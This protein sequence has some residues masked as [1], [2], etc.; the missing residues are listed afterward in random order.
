MKFEHLKRT[1]IRTASDQLE[2]HEVAY[3]RSL[4]QQRLDASA[5]ELRGSEAVILGAY[6]RSILDK[7]QEYQSE[8]PEA[9][10]DWTDSLWDGPKER[11]VSLQNIETAGKLG[12]GAQPLYSLL[13]LPQISSLDPLELIRLYPY[14]IWQVPEPLYEDNLAR[15]I[16]DNGQLLPKE[17]LDVLEKCIMDQS[18]APSSWLAQIQESGC[19]KQAGKEGVASMYA[20]LRLFATGSHDLPSPPAKVLFSAISRADWLKRVQTI[21]KLLSSPQGPRFHQRVV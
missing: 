19:I 16:R 17:I 2:A 7:A 14:L 20:L 9:M 3:I 4:A 10:L 11:L 21:R 13:S 12:D 18:C 5:D 15:W 6:C 1:P 8:D